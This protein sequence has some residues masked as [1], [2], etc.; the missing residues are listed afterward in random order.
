MNMVNTNYSSTED[1]NNKLGEVKG[2]TKLNFYGNISNF[3]NQMKRKNFQTQ[4]DPFSKDSP[5][6]SKVYHGV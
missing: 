3:Y 2:K 5:A 6:I 4:E 1:M